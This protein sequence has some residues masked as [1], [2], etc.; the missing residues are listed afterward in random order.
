MFTILFLL[1]IN[2]HL[3]LILNYYG[4]IIN[5][6]SLGL[7]TSSF[8]KCWA[9]CI[10]QNVFIL[11]DN[12]YIIKGKRLKKYLNTFLFLIEMTVMHIK[13]LKLP[14][15]MLPIKEQRRRSLRDIIK[16][17]LVVARS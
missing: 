8:F 1:R 17:F 2:I 7:S 3:S 16:D 6:I 11:N 4:E 9:P 5:Q 10:N 13:D 14:I 12:N 15:R